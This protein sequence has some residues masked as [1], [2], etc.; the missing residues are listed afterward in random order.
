MHKPQSRNG[1]KDRKEIPG[2]DLAIGEVK[3]Y[4]ASPRAVAIIVDTEDGTFGDHDE[5]VIRPM[6]GTLPGP[7]TQSDPRNSRPFILEGTCQLT[8]SCSIPSMSNALSKN[9]LPSGKD[10]LSS[11]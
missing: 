11:K 5:M 8:H 6:N 7:I 4:S 2:P 10:N 9:M 3:P 1:A